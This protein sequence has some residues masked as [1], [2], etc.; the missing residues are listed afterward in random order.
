MAFQVSIQKSASS[1]SHQPSN[2]SQ[3]YRPKPVSKWLIRQ[4]NDIWKAISNL[5]GRLVCFLIRHFPCCT[6]I[7]W[8]SVH[9]VF[10]TSSHDYFHQLFPNKN[11]NINLSQFNWNFN[12]TLLLWNV[13]KNDFN[14]DSYCFSV[15]GIRVGAS[16]Y[17]NNEEIA[18]QEAPAYTPQPDQIATVAPPSSPVAPTEVSYNDTAKP[19]PIHVELADLR[20]N[21]E[22]A[23]YTPP[24][25]T[26]TVGPMLAHSTVNSGVDRFMPIDL[27][28]VDELKPTGATIVPGTVILSLPFCLRIRFSFWKILHRLDKKL[29][30][31]K[32]QNSKFKI[33]NSKFKI[34]KFKIQ[35]SKFKIS[36]FKFQFII[37]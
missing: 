10:R 7:L 1:P 13:S 27:L 3:D 32:I 18:V 2:Q 16:E 28:E 30:K 9:Y 11:F 15:R 34:Q 33:Q 29:K 17:I 23:V 5:N 19:A 14:K 26:V 22:V 4:Q 35:N 37:P 21:D 8:N 6:I 24:P 31:F 20:D 36:N 25:I 12:V